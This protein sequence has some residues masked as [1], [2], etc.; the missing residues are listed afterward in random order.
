MTRIIELD[1]I[2]LAVTDID[3]GDRL[4][5]A[6]REREAVNSLVSLLAPGC[7]VGHRRNGAPF[8]EGNNAGNLHISISHS[9]T[10]AAVAISP[11]PV[12]IDIE[13]YREQLQRVKKRFLS[14]DELVVYENDNELLL[15]AWCA[16][17]A[18]YKLVQIDGLPFDTG[19]TLL[20]DLNKATA[21]ESIRLQWPEHN[22]A[23]A[24]Y[25][26]SKL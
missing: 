26:F 25:L 21:P 12:G 18:I 15:K 4:D 11:R 20:A 8:L 3:N 16:K 5:R 7:T 24:T 10:Q 2:T 22:L 14:A 23:V 6:A 9:R 1:D 17:E 19:I 13:D